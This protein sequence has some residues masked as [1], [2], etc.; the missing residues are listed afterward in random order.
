[1]DAPGADLWFNTV[2]YTVPALIAFGLGCVF[3]L[4]AYAAILW[5]VRTRRFVEIPAA[6]VVA[7]VSWEFLWSFVYT[8]DTGR[9]FVWGY[10]GWVFLDFF[11]VYC[12]F[13]YGPSQVTTPALKRWFA[14]A[15]AFGIASWS[16]ALYVFI[17]G[18]YDMS[19]GATSAYIINVMMSATYLVLLYTHPPELFSQVVAWSKGVG[20]ACFSLFMFMVPLHLYGRAEV[21]DKRFLLALTIITL[22]LD[23]AYV[24]AL[25]ARQRT[26]VPASPRVAA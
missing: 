23:A 3:W 14:P 5:H 21:A 12:L 9:A 22:A 16:A 15:V 7:N 2:R 10:R 25:Y 20:T 1:M 19:M 11:I 24:A 6:A 4:V 26:A 8:A 18:G 17:D 13:R